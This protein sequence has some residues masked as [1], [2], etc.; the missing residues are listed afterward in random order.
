[1]IVMILN[2]LIDRNEEK[3]M[4]RCKT[5]WKKTIRV[6]DADLQTTTTES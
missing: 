2:G 6:T 3:K 4:N 5:D 1:M